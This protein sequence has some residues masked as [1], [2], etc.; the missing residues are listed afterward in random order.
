MSSR[1]R[2]R[3]VTF[4]RAI[5]T[6][7]D[8]G[9]EIEVWQSVATAW[10]RVFWGRGNERREAAAERGEQPAT[11]AVLSNT[12]TRALTVRDRMISEG[13]LWD[14][15]GVAPVARGEIEITALAGEPATP[16]DIVGFAFGSGDGLAITGND[17]HVSIDELPNA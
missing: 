4:Q 3:L 6:Q 2:D 7:D 8:F 1:R 9:E 16:T 12:E 17:L 11:F 5:V 13:L 15:V 14:I 10:A